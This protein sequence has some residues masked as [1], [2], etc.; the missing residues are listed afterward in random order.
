[1]EQSTIQLTP[2]Q[3]KC[4]E[5]KSSVAKDLVIQGIAGSGKSTVLMARAKAFLSDPRFYVPGRSNQVI[6]FTYNNTLATYLREYIQEKFPV[7]SSHANAYTITTLDSYLSEVF[8]YTPGRF[9]RN[10]VDDK[11]RKWMMTQALANHKAKY[12]AHRFHSVDVDFWIEECKWM[13]AMNIS[14]DDESKYID[15]NFKRTGRGGKVQIRGTDRVVAF[16]IYRE[17]I[18]FLKSKFRCEFE[19]QHLYLSHHLDKIAD[20]FKYDHVLIDEAQD[21]SLTKMMIVAALSKVDVTISMDM[22]QRIYKQSWTLSQLGLK[23]VTKTLKTGFRCSPQND[24]LAESLRMHNPNADPDH[25][26]AQGPDNGWKPIIKT[27][28]SEADQNKYFISKIQSWLKS[29]PTAT[30]GVLYLTNKKGTTYGEWLT[31]KNIKFQ[32]IASGEQFSAISPGVKLSTIYSA[33]GLEFDHVIM[34]DFNEGVIPNIKG[35]DPELVEEELVKYRNLAYVAITRARGRLL[36]CTYGTPSRFIKEM[37]RSLYDVS[38][39]VAPAK[40]K[41]T[42]TKTATPVVTT[43][44]KPVK[45]TYVSPYSRDEVEDNVTISAIIQETK[46]ETTIVVD[47]KKY[48]IQRSIIGKRVGDTFNFSNINLTYKILAITAKTPRE[49]PPI[50]Y[51]E[52][53]VSA[54]EPTELTDEEIDEIN[55]FFDDEALTACFIKL[56]SH[57]C[58]LCDDIVFFNRGTII[59]FGRDGEHLRAYVGKGKDGSFFL[60][61][62]TSIESI[63]FAVKN[64]AVLTQSITKNNEQFERNIEKYT[65][66]EGASSSKPTK[67]TTST[68][69]KAAVA[70]STP[71]PTTLREFFES[72]GFQTVDLRGSNGCLWVIGEKTALEPIVNEAIRIFSAYGA[73][74]TGRAISY[75]PA[76]W[77]KS[78]K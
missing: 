76:W 74:G 70:K 15:T 77:T 69:K 28:T 53:S 75:K 21:Q 12:G 33:K 26:P 54:S 52:P 7:D 3:Q 72:K 25:G 36:I 64:I 47:L 78:N 51:Q 48:P 35:T 44:N 71:K 31:D 1:M 5:Y 66:S 22:N 58:S 43:V 10:P 6:I 55:E 50:T 27:C 23:S 30:I 56:F 32:K 45:S 29:D 42:P 68:A 20:R 34:L 61:T 41:T 37:D 16:Q 65:L 67:K 4:A 13:M 9:A 59:G 8:K 2:E 18:A 40:P 11:F 39:V 17:Y 63:P 49:T 24:A 38:D 19:E 60:K 14:E 62:K 46:K 57:Q 73:Y